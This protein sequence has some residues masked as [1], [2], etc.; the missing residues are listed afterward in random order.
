MTAAHL[1]WLALG[2]GALLLLWAGGQ[3]L[4]SGTDRLTGS[5]RLPAVSAD[6]AD[7]IA[8]IA[9]GETVIVTRTGP[10]AWSA[11]GFAAS[12]TAVA[13]FFG[14]LGQVPEPELVAR[15]AAS[16]GRLGV[17]TGAARRLRL[18]Q[19]GRTVLDLLV[20]E[21]GPDY[22][23]AYVRA[24]D[25]SA[26]YAV[27][28]SFALAARR[29]L[30][31]WRDRT[32]ATVSP[33]SV[34][35]IELWRGA[36]RTLLARRDGQWRLGRGAAD[37]AAVRRLLERYRSVTAAGFPTPAQLDSAFRGP[38]ERRVILRAGS[39]ETLLRLEFD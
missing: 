26:V 4:P 32:I 29:R 5:F 18:T 14:S 33:D 15:S 19:G 3:L 6:S 31:D 9:P 27:S 37:S 1:R 38:V 34:G 17:D 39:G 8:V 13:D 24:P 21:R 22:Q 20:S 16:F 35:E 2:V 23:S 10:G 25:D 12:S 30:D 36:R 28:G 7:T 11:N